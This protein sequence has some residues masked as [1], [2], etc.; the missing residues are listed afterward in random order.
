MAWCRSATGHYL[1][2]WWHSLLM[3]ICVTKPQWVKPSSAGS[4]LT[5]FVITV[6]R[7]SWHLMVLVNQTQCWLQ[8]QLCFPLSFTIM[9]SSYIMVHHFTVLGVNYCAGYHSLPLDRWYNIIK[10]ILEN[11]EEISVLTH[12]Q[13]IS[14]HSGDYIFIVWDQFHT[15]ILQLYGTL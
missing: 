2:Q 15:N 11:L 12:H 9:I 14:T 5:N 1:D 7:M 10:K 13:V 4:V 6:L 8:S 3:H